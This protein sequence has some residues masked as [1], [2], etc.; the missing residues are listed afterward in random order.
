VTGLP[1]PKPWA[2]WLAAAADQVET[3]IAHAR[4]RDT[5]DDEPDPVEVASRI[6][7]FLEALG[8]DPGFADARDEKAAS[9]PFTA[10]LR[11][12]GP[13]GVEFANRIQES[14]FHES[15]WKDPGHPL[16]AR[17]L[18]ILAWAIFRDL[19]LQE[20]DEPADDAEDE[21]PANRA[22]GHAVFGSRML[23]VDQ[24]A[25]IG[26]PRSRVAAVD[27]QLEIRAPGG[28]VI[29]SLTPQDQIAGLE[30]ETISALQ[31]DL[32]RAFGVAGLRLLRF[33]INGV[34]R[35]SAEL[36]SGG[37]F[38][39]NP[40]NI[41]I[42]GGWTALA[43]KL[44]GLRPARLK[45]AAQLLQRVC[46][47]TDQFEAGGLLTYVDRRG[48]GGGRRV[49]TITAGYVLTPEFQPR[50]SATLVPVP[51]PGREPPLDGQGQHFA[52]QLRLQQLWLLEMRRGWRDLLK[53]RGLLLAD[54]D[55][56]W[57]RLAERAG[58]P[59]RTTDR[60]IALWRG[61]DDR[62]PPFLDVSD[63]VWTLGEHWS[64]E[65]EFLLDGARRSAAASTRRLRERSR[66]QN[67]RK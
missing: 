18:E 4:A 63:D 29:A 65:L 17:A 60:V 48:R 50:R 54:P 26:D 5:R 16:G 41:R 20:A 42:Q 37:Y 43:D 61:G 10:I 12:I 28:Q 24:L 64:P 47:R 62:T 9:G 7:Q 57:T 21:A 56:V 8:G 19:P 3:A 32:R 15:L 1:P 25:S 34:Q 52:A 2:S 31:T 51:E 11:S 40:Q 44:G 36:R 46:L 53:N 27:N 49:L 23:V 22:A 66:T 39:G 14:Q 45:E 59:H 6:V 13:T 38:R 30:A 33:V 55:A 35:Q 67:P 58:L